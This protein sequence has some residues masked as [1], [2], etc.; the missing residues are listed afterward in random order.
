[1]WRML[2]RC[3]VSC[4][5]RPGSPTMPSWVR[6]VEALSALLAAVATVR[7]RCRGGA[8]GLHRRLSRDG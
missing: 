3:P 1:M 2:E 5:N 7:L 8:R 6:E 4:V